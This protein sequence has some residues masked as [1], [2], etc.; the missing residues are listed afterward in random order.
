[1]ASRVKTALS[2]DAAWIH[3]IKEKKFIFFTSFL[4][5][6]EQLNHKHSQE[7]QQDEWYDESEQKELDEEAAQLYEFEHTPKSQFY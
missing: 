2:Q 6:T 4:Q 3:S 5:I 1:M 7:P